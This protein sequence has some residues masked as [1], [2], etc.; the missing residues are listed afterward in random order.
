MGA[1]LAAWTIPFRTDV[2]KDFTAVVRDQTLPGPG[3]DAL[4]KQGQIPHPLTDRVE[5]LGFKI[6]SYTPDAASVSFHVTQY[7]HDFRCGAEVAWVGGATGDW[8]LRLQPDGNVLSTC[9]PLAAT[10]T[11]EFVAWGP[12]ATAAH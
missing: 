4:L 9:R 10:E 7:G 8:L 5:P 3:Q 6:L 1:V 11:G 2:A 12:I